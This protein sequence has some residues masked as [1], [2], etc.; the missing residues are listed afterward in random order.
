MKLEK[1]PFIPLFLSFFFYFFSAP[2]FIFIFL[3]PLYNWEVEDERGIRGRSLLVARG[4]V[5]KHRVTIRACL[6]SYQQRRRLGF[7]SLRIDSFIV[8]S[9][10][11]MNVPK[12]VVLGLD[13][14]LD[15][16]QLAV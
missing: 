14:V 6:V 15:L 16:L 11:F 1:H 13:S 2:F 8:E 10:T 9:L 5:G 7:S 12:E 4:H 3:S